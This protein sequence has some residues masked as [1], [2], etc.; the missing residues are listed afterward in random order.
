MNKDNVEF[1]QTEAEKDLKNRQAEGV[2]EISSTGYGLESVS[3]E[4]NRTSENDQDNHSG[5]GGL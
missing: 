5:C 2:L 4:E 1:G 3:K